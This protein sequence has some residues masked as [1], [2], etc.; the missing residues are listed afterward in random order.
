MT[1]NAMTGDRERC[2]KAG[3]DDYLSKPVKPADLEQ[4]LER[5]LKGYGAE[6][7]TPPLSAETFQEEE[8]IA[9][10]L[11]FDEAEILERL[12]NN[13]GLLQEIIAM[14]CA[15]L[16]LRLEQLQLAV[17]GEDR[18]S[19]QHAAHTIKG[20]AANLAALPLQQM[21]GRLEKQADSAELARLQVL[22]G[23]VTEQVA[24]LLHLLSVMRKSTGT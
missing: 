21:A 9:G 5:W 12:G 20:M 1:A 24:I 3:M 2:I 6:G 11:V 10:Q 7:R 4:M 14:A 17:A 18:I 23:E 16:P 15:D 19:L 13:R 8:N 22:A